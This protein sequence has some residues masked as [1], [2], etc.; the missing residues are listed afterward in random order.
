MV[1]S[2]PIIHQK[3]FSDSTLHFKCISVKLVLLL[4][5]YGDGGR[6]LQF[7]IIFSEQIWERT[8]LATHRLF[9]SPSPQRQV[10]RVVEPVFSMQF[11]K[12]I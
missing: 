4:Q 10:Y 2:A 7:P 6:I 12:V 8:H 11:L 5:E 1:L 3:Q 9:L